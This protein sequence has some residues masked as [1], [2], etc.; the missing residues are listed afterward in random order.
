V[1]CFKAFCITYSQNVLFVLCSLVK[2]VVQ[3]RLLSS[4][5]GCVTSHK[6]TVG[7]TTRDL[8]EN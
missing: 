6:S 8:S 2:S 7:S 3:W 5:I 1:Y 4:S